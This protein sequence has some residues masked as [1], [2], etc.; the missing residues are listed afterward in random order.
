MIIIKTPTR[1]SLCGGGSDFEVFF[2]QY[3]GA[4]IGSTINKYSYITIRDIPKHFG[5]NYKLVY[6]KI[7]TSQDIQKIDHKYFQAALD[8]FNINNVELHHISDLPGGLGL[9][10]SSAFMVCLVHALSVYQNK[11]Y[12]SLSKKNLSNTAINIE[13]NILGQ[14]G[15]WQD[16]IWSA[17][18]GLNL[19]KFYKDKT[20]DVNP[21]PISNDQLKRLEKHILLIDTNIHRDASTIAKSYISNEEKMKSNL[22]IYNLVQPAYEAII[23]ENYKELGKIITESWNIKKNLSN[24]VTNDKINEIEDISINKGAYGFKLLGSGGGGTCLI[25]CPPEIQKEILNNFIGLFKID[26]EF[27]N[28]GSKVILYDQ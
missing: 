3:S 15:G 25:L 21:I 10:S 16:Q 13:R 24:L 9:G 2:T 28:G 22:Q 4:V 12:A 14:S 23:S 5:C 8:Y 11:R 17:F 27:E 26:F 19:I 1:L 6:S 18:G 20:F 7:E